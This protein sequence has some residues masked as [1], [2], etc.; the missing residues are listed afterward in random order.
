MYEPIQ[1]LRLYEQIVN[2]IRQQIMDETLKDGDRLPNE[3]TL[4]RHYKVSR[5]VVR[6]AM[7][8]LINEGL[9]EVQQG[10]G[11]F[12]I[13]NTSQSLG[14]VLNSMFS[15]EGNRKFVELIEFRELLEPEI[16]ER[17]VLRAGDYDIAQLHAAFQGM[18][19]S[20]D[21][22][23]TY[24]R[25]DYKFHLALAATINNSVVYK[26][27]ESVLDLMILQ[28]QYFAS[29]SLETN[30]C[31]VHHEQILEAVVHQDSQGARLAMRAHL[32]QVREHWYK[33]N[34]SAIEPSR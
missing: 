29:N 24:F 32:R 30:N 22:K 25:E 5:T 10:L 23:D 3:Q 20:L 9:V 31:H 14:N 17:G 2:Q 1:S 16:A 33:N 26:L 21:D 7:K 6:E 28:R 8:A 27:I 12:V 19:N 15:F 11:T 18:C 13:D 4:A 34:P